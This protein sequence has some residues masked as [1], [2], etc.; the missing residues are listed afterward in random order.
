V[1]QEFAHHLNRFFFAVVDDAE[2]AGNALLRVDVAEEIVLNVH[3]REGLAVEISQLF[4][5]QTSFECDGLTHARPEEHYLALLGQEFGVMQRERLHGIERSLKICWQPPELVNDFG[6]K[7]LCLVELQFLS[8]PERDESQADDLTRVGFGARDG[9]FATAINEH[10]T[11]VFTSQGAV[12]LVDHIESGQTI[13]ER[14]AER[15]EQVHCFA[16]L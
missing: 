12:D 13:F 2:N 5:L 10:T 9:E 4:H 6:T 7:A 1:L 14:F 11:V 3:R 16:G 8:E 15:N